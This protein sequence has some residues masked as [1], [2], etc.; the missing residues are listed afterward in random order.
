MFTLPTNSLGMKP[1]TAKCPCLD[2]AWLGSEDWLPTRW[3][4]LW[5]FCA[6]LLRDL[7][8]CLRCWMLPPLTFAM[9]ADSKSSPRPFSSLAERSK[10][11]LVIVSALAYAVSS[12]KIN[13][14]TFSTERFSLAFSFLFFKY[15]VLFYWKV[16]CQ[17]LI[18]IYLVLCKTYIESS[19]TIK[20]HLF[21]WW[22]GF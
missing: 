18:K 2:S 15:F 20:S 6:S 13:G 3:F 21:N 16:S 19:E 1:S 17:K 8:E 10:L 11:T 5:S 4:L 9:A 22:L 12:T 14:V 7:P